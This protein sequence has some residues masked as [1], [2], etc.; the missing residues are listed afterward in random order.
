MLR[1]GLSKGGSTPI[2]SEALESLE[3]A[4][5]IITRAI[6]AALR[7][8][9]SENYRLPAWQMLGLRGLGSLPQSAGQFVVSRLQSLH[10]LDPHQLE[11][12]R[13]PDILLARLGDYASLKDQF[14]VI[15]IGSGLG[16]ATAHLATSL[17]GPFLPTAFVYTLRGGAPDGDV[18][19][20]FNLS[21]RLALRLAEQLPEMLT[22]QHYDPVHDGWLT[23]S[24]NHLRL[25]LGD[26]PAI[27]QDFIRGRLAP[28][29]SVIYLECTA[30][31][32]R[33]R[34]GPRSVFQ[35][36][37]WGDLLPQD[38]LSASEPLREYA[39][40]AGLAQWDW[41]L[42]GYPLESGP[43]SEWGCESD[44]SEAL[45]AFCRRNAIP[46]LRIR[47]FD[48]HAY[49]RLAFFARQAQLASQGIT[50]A[51]VQVEIFSQFDATA[52]LRAALLPL[53][54]VFNTHTSLEFLKSMRPH[55]PPDKPVFFSSLATFSKT[56]DL[57]PWQS[58][59]DALDGLDL[60]LCGARP[61]HYPADTRLLVDWAK[62]GRAWAAAHPQPVPE[63]LPVAHLG[64]ILK[65]LESIES[66]TE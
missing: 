21:H 3:S 61:S 15:L 6:T 50:P 43:E 40:S 19:R 41:R 64:A 34:V 7:G 32:L 25:K 5:P 66:G 48:P 36:G 49:G 27:Y 38:Y 1:S 13:L 26:L 57:V 29:G 30:Q 42:P 20:Y 33:Y 54:L 17:G 60:R 10:G 55:F 16:G 28:G 56:P 62:H 2:I 51:G 46:L 52:A 14:P 8:E 22:I 24:I 53:W 9:Y 37:G 59:L 39:R 18:Q 47:Y 11:Q 31:W 44:F 4:S 35:V 65:Q 12:L 23:R 58:W 45:E 63:P